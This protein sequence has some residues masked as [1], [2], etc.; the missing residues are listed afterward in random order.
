[1]YPIAIEI[2]GTTESTTSATFLD[3]LPAIGRDS[4]LETSI[5]DK[6]DDFNSH[7]T[8]FA[9]LSSNYP[10]SPAYGVFNLYNMPRLAPDIN[11]LFF[12]VGYSNRDTPSNEWNR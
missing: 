1:M 12:P 6:R 10:S 5:Y 4:Q 8:N 3:L 7:I 2:K 9:F 11:A